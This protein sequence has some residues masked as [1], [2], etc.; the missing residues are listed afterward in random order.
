MINPFSTDN[1]IIL[2]I[3]PGLQRGGAEMML[4]HL[5]SALN[6]KQ[7]NKHEILSLSASNEFEDEHKK[8]GIRVYT[9]GMSS[10]ASLPV[11]Y[12][13]LR[14]M[15]RSINPAMIHGWM[16]HGNMA[17]YHAGAKW[18]LIYS[19]HNSFD[20]WKH[21]KWATRQ[22]IRYGAMISGYA[23]ALVY[24]S[25]TSMSQHKAFGFSNH[26][27]ICI[28][29]GIDTDK[30]KPDDSA[31]QRLR[32]MLGIT[33][34][35]FLFGQIARYHPI[36]NQVG[37]IKAFATIASQ[38]PEAYL[39][40]IGKDCDTD[41]ISL[42]DLI[43]S[44]GL[45]NRVHLT[46]MRYDIE[47]LLPGLDVLV[48]PSLSEA[49]PIVVCEAMACGVPCVAT[50]VGDT[51]ELIGQAGMVVNKNDIKALA[52]A[53]LTMAQLSSDK[54]TDMGRNARSI[55]L[56]HYRIEAIIDMYQTLYESLNKKR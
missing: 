32:E 12:F 16:Y 22:V 29:N 18:P 8:A 42:S 56:K 14:K 27:E 9:L 38:I 17:S 52:E 4:T 54:R 34:P 5:V 50:D 6:R 7:N 28:P 40:M 39:V 44:Y 53:L 45:T 19:I 31:R 25:G 47:K 21:E 26:K 41:N 51:R 13:R 23:D 36:K 24:C 48:S 43:A 15:V 46:G 33:K 49:F 11:Q 1:K 20:G 3:T 30:F 10:L 55:V 37:L 2:H 35:G